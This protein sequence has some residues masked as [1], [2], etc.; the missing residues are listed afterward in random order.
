MLTIFLYYFRQEFK[1]KM[2]FEC[3]KHLPNHIKVKLEREPD[4]TPENMRSWLL[5]DKIFDLSQ[6]KPMI[7]HIFIKRFM[8]KLRTTWSM[9]RKEESG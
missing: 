3:R 7:L 4:I 2:N 8:D 6:V 9:A 5:G 1:V